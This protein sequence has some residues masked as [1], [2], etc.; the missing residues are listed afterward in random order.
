VT[1]IFNKKKK[2]SLKLQQG[3]IYIW[4]LVLLTFLSLGLGQWSINYATL[5]Q[6]EQEQELLRI[7]LMYRNAIYQYYDNSPNGSKDFP[8]RL[9]DLLKDPRSLEVKRY[10]RKL[11]LDPMT[12]KPFILIKNDN[13]RIVGVY[14][15]SVK[16]PL[17]KINFLPSL[18]NFEEAINYQG[19]QFKM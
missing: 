3:S 17:K 1:I 15:S 12:S 18:Q 13:D 11:E 4:M 5:K 9:E 10:L 16:K 7:G 19:W 8:N 14:S 2:S 6:R